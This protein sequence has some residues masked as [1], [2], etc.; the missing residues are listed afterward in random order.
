MNEFTMVNLIITLEVC[1]GN[2]EKEYKFQK[3]EA[4]HRHV[5]KNIGNIALWSQVSAQRQGPHRD[6]SQNP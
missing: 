5:N 1:S 3:S 6:K 4:K 2:L